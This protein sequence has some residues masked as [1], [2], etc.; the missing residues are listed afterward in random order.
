MV[1]AESEEKIWQAY[2]KQAKTIAE[3]NIA[4][5]DKLKKVYLNF[6]ASTHNNIGV[7]A[8]YS[9]DNNK[10]LQNFKESL[11]ISKQIGDK[12]LETEALNNIGYVYDIQGNIPLALEYFH[13]SLK[14]YEMLKND[15][16]TSN[17]LNNIATIYA[18]QG[19]RDKALEYHNKSLRKR[20]HINDKA[21]IA[22]S[23]NNIG[24]IYD[25]DG[26]TRSLEFYQKSFAIYKAIGDQLGI[27][28]ASNNIGSI[29]HRQGNNSLALSYFEMSLKI[30]NELQNKS[31]AAF[32]L[33]NIASLFL[34]NKN[35]DEALPY[36]SKSMQV[37]K[38]VG[39]PERIKSSADILKRIFIHQKKYKEAFEMYELEIKMRDSIN[40]Q[41]TQKAA[42]KK[43]LQYAYEKKE[44]EIKA[45]QDKK[46]AVAKEALKQKEKERNYFIAGFALV[47]L[48]VLFIL[49]GYWQKQKAHKI[50]IT[51]KHLV[52]EKQKEI[53]DSI[54]YA[55]RI[56]LALLPSE[57][58]IDKT[59]K[60]L[61]KKVLSCFLLLVSFVS[62]SQN[63]DSLKLA[64]KNATHDTTRC[65]ILN[66]IVE[67]ESDDAI[68]PKYNE[69]LKKLAEKNITTN[70]EFKNIYLKYLSISINNIG[71]LYQS[72][73][74]LSK[75]LESMLAC[76]KIQ[77]EIGFKAG[78]AASLNRIGIIYDY[79]GNLS[80]SLESYERSLKIVEETGDKS[81]IAHSLNNIGYTYIRQ[82]NIKGLDYLH[83]SLKL[84]E[85]MN[86]KQGL[87]SSLNNIGYI[88][89]E[90]GDFDNA[91]KYYKKS[92]V[93][94]EEL[95]EKKSIA[96]ALNNIGGVYSRQQKYADALTNYR[97]SI[98]I[99]EQIGDK[100]G[101]ANALV[102]IGAIFQANG[103]DSANCS[104]EDAI[105]S[106]QTKALACFKKSLTIREEIDDKN[107]ICNTLN[108]LAGLMLQT[109]KIQEA[110]LYGSKAMQIAKELGY[111]LNIQY[112]A[113]NLKTI[114]KKQNKYKEAL[115]M[116]ELEMKMRDSINNQ[117]TQ[118]A[119]IKKQ[120]QYT[121]E[122]KELET[123]AQQDKKDAIA[124]EALKQK[125]KERNY[126]IS[127]FSIVLVLALFILRGYRQ[128]QKDNAIITAQ[129]QLVDVKQ[130]EILDSIHYANRIQT[131]LLP[132]EKYIGKSLKQLNKK[133]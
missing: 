113:T 15:F 79:Q 84:Y 67:T 68:W 104:K 88:Y 64:L 57:K 80:K 44:L 17:T 115:E 99:S 13:E 53:L 100:S 40:N 30:H 90:Q 128:K 45:K 86:D 118:K 96:R 29:Y 87:S 92:L 122:K 59:L 27:A 94:S 18:K 10:A 31:G 37:A 91:L 5:G 71:V 105:R 95:K 112:V 89:E 9:G 111:P 114:Y 48:L 97:K 131:A 75:G 70:S 106:R 123:K 36:A 55:R 129:K 107:G 83:K 6:L 8:T 7:G 77:E 61:N 124:K 14:L 11:S 73:G 3:K 46:D 60:Q 21:G 26:G 74:N 39:Y 23:L 4:S 38:E 119:A 35:Y 56:Q 62:F 34:K 81:A 28:N 49:R 20:E 22:Q 132:S 2:N 109:G 127:G 110:F 98:K 12:H 120:M 51:Q 58:Y 47:I 130:K 101:E 76:L 103:F 25:A 102:K 108:C 66:L 82:G 78:I 43:E 50:I 69:Q 116:Y 72:E 24:A 19:E 93:V 121:F 52:D 54:H 117:E 1:E 32:T 133:V 41:E 16:G 42:V 125:E 65:N 126:F 63:T 33:N 85:E